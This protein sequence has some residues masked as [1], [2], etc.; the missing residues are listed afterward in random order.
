LKRST[1]DGES[2]KPPLNRRLIQVR[3]HLLNTTSTRSNDV[4]TW[5]PFHSA[6][7]TTT[8]TT[9][10]A[11]TTAWGCL[12]RANGSRCRRHLPKRK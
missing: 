3:L 12:G 10:T 6:A 2:K 9:T 11:D 4:Q 5:R 7:A 8:T 1:S